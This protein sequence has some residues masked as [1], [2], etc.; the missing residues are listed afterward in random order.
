DPC[1]N[2]SPPSR[3]DHQRHLDRGPEITAGRARRRVGRQLQP[4]PVPQDSD[5]NGDVSH[6]GKSYS[7]PRRFGAATGR[8]AGRGRSLLVRYALSDEA[9]SGAAIG[10]LPTFTPT[11]TE[12]V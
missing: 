4:F 6:E 8:A 12:I 7:G 3:K 11:A 5:R 1:R 2:P 10:S 9:R